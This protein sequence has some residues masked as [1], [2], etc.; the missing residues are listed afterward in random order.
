MAADGLI[1]RL[2]LGTNMLA[3]ADEVRACETMAQISEAFA[4]A[5]LPLGMT[6]SSSG[7]V[8]GPRSL[9][10]DIF[11]FV[12]WPTKWLA[13]YQTREFAKKD[14]V[15][16]WAIVSGMPIAWSE[17]MRALPLADPGHE[18][19]AAAQEAGFS[20]GF[21]T[22]VRAQDGSFGLVSVGGSREAFDESEKMF[23][24]GISAATLH[25]AE[26]VS[27]PIGEPPVAEIFSRREREC[28]SLLVQGFTDKEIGTVLGVSEGTARFH[29]DNARRKVGARSRAHLVALTATLR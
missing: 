16:R 29:I 22:P 2:D 25:R 8:S 27:A 7:M 12:N 28:L 14:P 4:R 10:D 5:I 23:L 11:H 13:L 6:A 24:Q 3:F 21:I 15:P 20:E 17:M 1:D 19:Y 26:A 18:V 9:S